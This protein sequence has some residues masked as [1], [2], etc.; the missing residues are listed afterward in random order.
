MSH[1]TE[2]LSE[3]LI[4]KIYGFCRSKVRSEQDAEDLAQDV[5]VELLKAFRSGKPVENPNAFAWSVSQHMFFNW[6]RK[7]K[8][9]STAVYLTDQFVSEESVE[10]AYILQE[11][12]ALLRRELSLLSGDYRKAV[13]LFYFDGMT[14]AEI[15]SAL[16]KPAGTIKW[17]LHDA[18]E[19]I[20]KG[21]NTMKTY[22]EKSYR[23]GSL[24]LSCQGMPGADREPV[25]CAKRKS[26]QNILLAAYKQPVTIEGLCME[27]GISA[28]YVEDEVDYLVEN[29]LMKEVSKGS[30]QTDFVILSGQNAEL[31]NKIYETAF[32]AYYQK[33][34][35]HLT[36][37]RE[38]LESSLCNPAGFSWERLLWVYLHIIPEVAID[39]F[40]YEHNIHV[41]GHDMPDRPNGGKWIALGFENGLPTQKKQ[42]WKPYHPY[43]G[44]VHKPEAGG[45]V[46]GFFHYWSGVDSTTYFDLPD[47]VLSLGRDIQMGVVSIPDLTEEQKYLFSIALEQKLFVEEGDTFRPNYYCVSR[48][49]SDILEKIANE[50]YG[51]AEPV[52]EQLYD[53]ILQEYAAGIPEHLHWQMGNFLSNPLTMLVTCSL[54]EA[55]KAGVLS[56]P[57]EGNAYWLSLFTSE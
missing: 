54:Y 40:K 3:E 5:C 24:F 27:L 17:W 30:Y 4:Q 57:E 20:R 51:E 32:P 7:K 48:E 55:K 38:T 52:M 33:L 50:F 10:Q 23:P 28:P 8:R 43:D 44:P 2:L 15:G 34:M 22:G 42:D 49:G 53:L 9:V 11:Q 13:V 45:F 21:M 29:Q 25:I 12:K 31:G 26:A 39:R 37:N 16:G 47:E 18:K 46:Q 41:K 6:L 19:A 56:E 14:C 36:S 35:A 1:L